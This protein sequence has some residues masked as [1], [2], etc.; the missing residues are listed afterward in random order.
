MQLK[1]T[2]SL[3]I[4]KTKSNKSNL[5]QIEEVRFLPEFRIKRA[6]IKDEVYFMLVFRRISRIFER[7]SI[8]LRPESG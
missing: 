6:R 3:F 2:L 5:F 4:F 1:P 7:F 8:I